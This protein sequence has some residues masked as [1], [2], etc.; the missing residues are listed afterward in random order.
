MTHISSSLLNASNFIAAPAYTTLALGKRIGGK[1]RV[2]DNSFE[3]TGTKAVLNLL[4]YF[5]LAV[6]N[7]IAIIDEFDSGIHDLLVQSLAL[8]ASSSIL[9]NGQLI[10][11]THNT[12]LMEC[13]NKESIY[14]LNENDDGGKEINCILHY[15]NK[16]GDKANIRKQYLDGAFSSDIGP[17][18]K[19]IP[20]RELLKTITPEEL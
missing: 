12:R 6:G 14:V 4:P 10:L 17:E 9:G 1:E 2:I 3:S 15:D 5:L 8:S 7:R 20:F 11:T 18:R 16:L 13:I 19:Y